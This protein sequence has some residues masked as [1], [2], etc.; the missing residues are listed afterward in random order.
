MTTCTQRTLHEHPSLHAF[1]ATAHQATN[2]AWSIPW[3]I[4]H[5]RHDLARTPVRHYTAHHITAR[6]AFHERYIIILIYGLFWK[7]CVLWLLPFQWVFKDSWGNAYIWH[8]LLL[9][10]DV[11][12]RKCEYAWCFLK[13]IYWFSLVVL[14]GGLVQGLLSVSSGFNEVVRLNRTGNVFGA[15]HAC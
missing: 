14:A 9:E 11:L 12:L 1:Q 3:F 5:V 10:S 4:K 2:V 13:A 8:F 6:H 7:C 15:R